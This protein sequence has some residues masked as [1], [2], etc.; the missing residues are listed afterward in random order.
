MTEGRHTIA[1]AYG[2]DA[3]FAPGTSNT[4]SQVVGG[5]VPVQGVDG[6][7]ILSARVERPHGAHAGSTILVLTF[8]EPLDWRRAED[9]ANYQLVALTRKGRTIRIRSAVYA[10]ASRSVTLQPVHRLNRHGHYRL[11]VIGTG[12]SGLT[13]ILGDLLDGQMNGHPGSDY[14][15]IVP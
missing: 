1:A 3:T 11:S 8:D 13:D 2:G 14:V 4:V 10:S 7:T 5:V 9:L 12:S 6:P 15:T